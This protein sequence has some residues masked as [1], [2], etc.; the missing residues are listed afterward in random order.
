[1]KLLNIGQALCG[2]QGREDDI[3][4][5]KHPPV[6]DVV[7]AMRNRYKFVTTPNL[8]YPE[9]TP[10]NLFPNVIFRGGALEIG[11]E[12]ISIGHMAIASTSI[13]VACDSSE[14]G[15][16]VVDDVIETL[17]EFGLR[18]GVKSV[19]RQYM[20]T[21]VVEFE[22]GFVDKVDLIEK[23]AAII[24]T[25]MP[26]YG[27]SEPVRFKR[28]SFGRTVEEVVSWDQIVRTS[29]TLERRVGYDFDENKYFCS[30]PMPSGDL[31]E[32][33]KQIEEFVLGHS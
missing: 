28:L 25:K 12:K 14:S 5:P 10:T 15:D 21:M 18:Y 11:D 1:M 19:R 8:G 30:A 27:S 17:S 29:F 9:E 16:K 31:A 32:A 2:V 23:I 13:I 26:K 4:S 22:S 3:A 24:D 20:T 6:R 7:E 33:L